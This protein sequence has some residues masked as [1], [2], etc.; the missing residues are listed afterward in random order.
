MKIGLVLEGG[1]MRGAFTAGVI[2]CLLDNHIILNN[3]YGISSGGLYACLYATNHYELIKKAATDIASDKRNV[4]IYPLLHERQLVA[5]DLLYDKQLV[6]NGYHPK[7]LLNTDVCVNVGVYDLFQ[8]KAVFIDNN[9]LSDNIAWIKAACAL[10]IFSR[11]IEIDDKLYTDAG[12]TTMI[13]VQKALDDGCDKLLIIT[14]KDPQ[15][16]RKPM[17]KSSLWILK[18][19]IY[20]K[21]DQLNKDLEHRHLA[22]NQQM[23][24]VKTLVAEEKA[25]NLFPQSDCGVSRYKGNIDNLTKLY[26]H[27]YDTCLENLSKIIDFFQ[28]N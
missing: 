27:G 21:Y 18:N 1:G 3:C 6:E 19:L 20:K 5:Y 26:Q 4:G 17:K 9:V 15:F 14:T 24:H 12:I 28:I 25:I 2:N 22:Y 8:Q 10:P 11:F 23:E 16:I 13:P 7:Q